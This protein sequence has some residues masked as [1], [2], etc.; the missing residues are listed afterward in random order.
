MPCPKQ[1]DGMMLGQKD[2]WAERLH[3]L[4]KQNIK[5]YPTDL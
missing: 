5:P 1:T 3:H 2:A 4:A